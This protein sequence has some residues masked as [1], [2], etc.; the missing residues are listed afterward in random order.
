MTSILLNL[1]IYLSVSEFRQLISGCRYLKL[2]K[3]SSFH[4]SHVCNRC[5]PAQKLSSLKLHVRWSY[6]VKYRSSFY[7]ITSYWYVCKVMESKNSVAWL[8]YFLANRRAKIADD[9]WNNLAY[10][11]RTAVN[12]PSQ[13]NKMMKLNVTHDCIRQ[14]NRHFSLSPW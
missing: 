13:S 12:C 11:L 14:C 5:L 4:L 8:R 1:V 3:I 10:S 7:C 2:V 6:W 9:L